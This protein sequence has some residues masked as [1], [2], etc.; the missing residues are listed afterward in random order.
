MKKHVIKVSEVTTGAL[1]VMTNNLP[2][3]E[4]AAISAVK[5]IVKLQRKD[6]KDDWSGWGIKFTGL[7]V[8]TFV[9]SGNLIEAAKK[10]GVVNEFFERRD[11]EDA[12][13]VIAQGAQLGWNAENKAFTF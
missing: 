1:V 8:V 7:N 5:A 10:A 2:T 9:Q 12:P 11:T 6:G 3:L 4:K 13:W